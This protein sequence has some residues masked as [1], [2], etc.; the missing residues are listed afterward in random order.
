MDN[1]TTPLASSRIRSLAVATAAAVIAVATVASASADSEASSGTTAD[2]ADPALV[3]VATIPAAN[4]GGL[5]HELFAAFEQETDFE[6]AIEVGNVFGRARGGNAD[7]VIVHYGAPGLDAFVLDGFGTW[8]QPT[9]A[10]AI[11]LIVPPGDPARVRQSGDPVEAFE[12]IAATESPFIVNNLPVLLHLSDTLWHAAGMPDKGEWFQDL[13]L[14][15]QAAVDE[16]RRQ[17]GYTLFGLHPFLMQPQQGVQPVL[18]DDVLMQ[19]MITSVVVD[20]ARVPD[21]NVDGALA[22]QAFLLEPETQV[23]IRGFRLAGIDH[24]VFWPAAERPDGP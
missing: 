10:N 24:R 1:S 8:P 13:G 11:A 16:A 5:L 6:V 18:F 19:A 2:A 21:V 22:L 17:R 3:R 12:R 4:T 9:M 23:R 15:G 20:P 7:L 14:Q